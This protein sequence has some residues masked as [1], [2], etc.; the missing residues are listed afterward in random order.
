MWTCSQILIVVGLTFD[1][2]SVLYGVI[3]TYLFKSSKKLIGE[4]Q[5]KPIKDQIIEPMNIWLVSLILL[6]F[7]LLLQGIAEFV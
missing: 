7:G 1:F 6:F 3:A 5:K 4:D 2:A